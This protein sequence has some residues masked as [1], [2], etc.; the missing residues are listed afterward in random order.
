MSKHFALQLIA[1]SGYCLDQTGAIAA[2]NY[3]TSLGFQLDSQVLSRRDNRFAATQQQRLAEINSLPNS[4]LSADIVM[5]VRGGYGASQL[6]AEIDYS[7]FRS[8]FSSK[9]PIICGH[10]DFTAIQLALLA[11]AQFI[12]FSGP[13]LYSNYAPGN[14]SNFTHE[15]LINLISQTEYQINWQTSSKIQG[16]WTGTLWGGNLTLIASVVGTAYLPSISQGILVIEDIN[17]P[18]YKI[19]R[20]LLQLHYA[21]ILS[22]QQLIITGDFSGKTNANYDQ[23]Y[24]YAEVWARITELSGIPILSGLKFG[25]EIDTVTLPIGAKA[26]VSATANNCCMH[27]SD[28]PTLN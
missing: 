26:H 10:S 8:T 5:A 15:N 21:G 1:P 22:N 19:E 25:H 24:G 7:A 11:Q 16:Q 9:V 27:L 13:M 14:R 28:Y 23:E 12:T 6:L 20:M 4:A 3:L 2:V 18:P 17:E